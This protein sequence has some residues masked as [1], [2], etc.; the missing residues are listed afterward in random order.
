MI[1]RKRAVKNG[2]VEQ[3]VDE[4]EKAGYYSCESLSD[5]E[6]EEGLGVM[7]Q[8]ERQRKEGAKVY[9]EEVDTNVFRVSM[10]CLKNV[11]S[12][13]Q[14]PEQVLKCGE[15]Q[16][17][18]NKHSRISQEGGK[19]AWL[20]EFCNFNN[21]NLPENFTVNDLPKEEEVTYCLT[22]PEVEKPKEETK[23]EET[24]KDVSDSGSIIF[25]LDISGS[26]SGRGKLVTVVGVLQKKLADLAANHPNKKVGLVTFGVD[27]AICLGTATQ[28][29]AALN[30]P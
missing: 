17:S 19:N 2:H 14:P 11:P 28:A 8:Q 1:D 25:C 15:C 22:P 3:E 30:E 16:V 6:M 7:P 13:Y 10:D 26:M 20:C 18:I 29:L 21:N 4:Q 23:M 9:K 12:T 24:K 27:V 5:N